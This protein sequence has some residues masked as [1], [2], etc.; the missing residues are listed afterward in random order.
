MK[1]SHKRPAELLH[2]N[3]VNVTFANQESRL[4]PTVTSSGRRREDQLTQAEGRL[5][6][7]QDLLLVWASGC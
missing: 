1:D 4:V 6:L 5:L 3:M 7:G 2:A